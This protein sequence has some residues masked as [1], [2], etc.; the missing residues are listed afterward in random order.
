MNSPEERRLWMATLAKAPPEQLEIVVA[1]LG[2]LPSYQH[3][4]PPEI[5]LVMVRGRAGG[6]GQQFNLGEMTV[7]RCVVRLDIPEEESSIGFGYVAGRSRQHAELAAVCDA[8]MQLPNWRH[9]VQTAVIEPLNAEAAR[10]Q[11]IQKR[12]TAATKV[13]FFT[14]VRGE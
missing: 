11:D 1:T 7:T 8:L 5:G 2:E 3:L 9:R 13:N 12:Q 4:R 10:R 14:M 6:T